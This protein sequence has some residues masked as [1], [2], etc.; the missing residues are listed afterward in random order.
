M[1]TNEERAV[2]AYLAEIGARGGK[3]TAAKLTKAQ[4][5][6]RARKAVAARE[7]KKGGK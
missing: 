5:V 3:K 2:K 1:A 4:R 7:A 6:E